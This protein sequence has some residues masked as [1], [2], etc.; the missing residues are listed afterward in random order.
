MHPTNISLSFNTSHNNVKLNTQEVAILQKDLDT[1]RNI[2][3]DNKNLSKLD[4]ENITNQLRLY[5]ETIKPNDPLIKTSLL[6]FLSNK[7]IPK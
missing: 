5:E 4:K 7:K 3:A 1:L 6:P 2:S